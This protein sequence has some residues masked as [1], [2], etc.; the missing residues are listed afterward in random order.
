MVDLYPFAKGYVAPIAA[1]VILAA[2]IIGSFMLLRRW[3]AVPRIQYIML[4][5]LFGAGALLVLLWFENTN[6]A[7]YVSTIFQVVGI[8]VAAYMVVVTN[9]RNTK[10]QI[11]TAQRETYQKLELSSVELFRFECTHPEFAQ[12]LWESETRSER[13]EPRQ[14]PEV[15]NYQL[16]EYIF[17][18]L[19]LFEMACRFRFDGIIKPEIFGSWVIW[20][21]QLC[22]EPVFHQ[23]WHSDMRLHYIERFRGIVDKGVWLSQVHGKQGEKEARRSFFKFV[24]EALGGCEVVAEWLD[25]ALLPPCAGHTAAVA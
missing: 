4:L 10:Q 9:D 25:H 16:R 3:P 22:R 20:I 23:E 8:V 19:N 6:V 7:R 11:E 15:S 13:G 2:A 17:Q 1:S 21:W 12:L 5:C 14:L 24:S 18:M